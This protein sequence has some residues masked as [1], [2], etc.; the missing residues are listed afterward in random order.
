MRVETSNLE[1]CPRSS[2]SVRKGIRTLWNQNNYWFNLGACKVA[3]KILKK[4]LI[5]SNELCLEK[6]KVML[7]DRKHSL[8]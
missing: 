2:L 4:S 6:E 5:E 1:L 7:S 8:G 3:R